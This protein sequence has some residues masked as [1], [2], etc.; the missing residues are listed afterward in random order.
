MAKGN[1]IITKG[2]AGSI[3]KQIVFRT[4]NGKTFASKY[5]DMS[6]VKP[7]KEQLKYKSAFSEAVEF[8][9]SVI[10]DPKKKAAYKVKKGAS[11]YH[12]AIRDYM[13]GQATQKVAQKAS[14]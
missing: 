3:G 2:L 13:R 10:R 12:T 6:K 11:V 4:R 7:S 14:K 5:P 1:N 8:A 9:Q